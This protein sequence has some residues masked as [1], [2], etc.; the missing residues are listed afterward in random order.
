MM[1]DLELM[2]ELMTAIARSQFDIPFM[3]LGTAEH[4]TY[5]ELADRLGVSLLFEAFADRRYTP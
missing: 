5:S 1:D 2:E 4:Q 3:I